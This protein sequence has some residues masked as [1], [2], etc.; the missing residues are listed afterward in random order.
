MTISFVFFE[1]IQS[2]KP[3]F[4]PSMIAFF[5]ASGILSLNAS[6]ATVSPAS[7]SKI[8]FR[9]VL[10]SFLS[11]SLSPLDSESVFEGCTGVDGI[12]FID[13]I[14]LSRSRCISFAKSRISFRNRMICSVDCSCS[15]NSLASI[16]LRLPCFLFFF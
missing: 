10:P 16:L 9:V 6:N 2:G 8:P 12:S 15:F 4:N 5:I 13:S 11:L 7:P 1:T 14:N 3:N